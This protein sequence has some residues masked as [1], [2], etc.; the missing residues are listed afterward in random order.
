MTIILHDWML[1]VCFMAS[2]IDLQS[3]PPQVSSF[4]LQCAV[5]TLA[6]SAAILPNSIMDEAKSNL[7]KRQEVENNLTH[8]LKIAQ[9]VIVDTKLTNDPSQDNFIKCESHL[10]V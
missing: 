4:S 10:I 9:S 7:T 8:Y 1:Q 3:S 2:D 6:L 5:T